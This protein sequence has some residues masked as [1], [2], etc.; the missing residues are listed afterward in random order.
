MKDTHTI[1]EKMCRN[2]TKS[3]P[4]TLRYLGTGIGVVQ[5]KATVLGT[6]SI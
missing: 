6:P 1:T 3:H 2:A 4:Y 5:S